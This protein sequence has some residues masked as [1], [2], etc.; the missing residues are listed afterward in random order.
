LTKFE[1]AVLSVEERLV[2]LD[3]LWESL[4]DAQEVF[5]RLIGIKRF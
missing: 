1:I 4:G 2:L 3:H 5:P